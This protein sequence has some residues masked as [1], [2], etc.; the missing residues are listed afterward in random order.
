M[1]SDDRSDRF[2][3]GPGDLDM[4]RHPDGTDCGLCVHKHRHFASC[5]AFPEG[6]PEAILD[7]RVGHTKPYPGD[8]GLRYWV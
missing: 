7:G 6:I 3:W 5:E 2:G 8:H 1:A 4:N